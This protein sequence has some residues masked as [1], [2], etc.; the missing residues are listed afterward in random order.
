M[1]RAVIT[2]VRIQL[3]PFHIR[4]AS[5]GDNETAGCQ[6][7]IHAACRNGDRPM[8]CFLSE[9]PRGRPCRVLALIFS[10]KSCFTGICFQA[11]KAG[12]ARLPQPR[13]F[14][15]NFWPPCCE[16]DNRFKFGRQ[17]FFAPF[18]LPQDI[19]QPGDFPD[20]DSAAQRSTPTL[21]LA[22]CFGR[23][24]AG[25]KQNATMARSPA[26]QRHTPACPAQPAG[27]PPALPPPP[28]R[29]LFFFPAKAEIPRPPDLAT[30]VYNARR[31]RLKTS[32]FGAGTSGIIMGS[33]TASY[34]PLHDKIRLDRR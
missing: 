2:W 9:L 15:P 24:R 18:A 27:A 10:R 22:R 8:R 12:L 33:E 14:G 5:G 30:V 23:E 16:E 19:R 11:F 32:R 1:P 25:P 28:D 29:F 26:E 7:A 34:A 20:F 3:S 4:A 31:R 13:N 21:L 17:P 6:I